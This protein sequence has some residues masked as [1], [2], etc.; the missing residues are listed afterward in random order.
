MEGAVNL[1]LYRAPE[2]VPPPG[3]AV[4]GSLRD[5]QLEVRQTADPEEKRE[6]TKQVQRQASE[7]LSDLLHWWILRMT[8]TRAPLVENMTLFWHGHFATSAEKV[9]QP[10]KT[11]L[12][13][14]TFR[15]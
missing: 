13:N 11:W 9:R 6:L 3:W 14:E 15:A 10:H 7:E 1:L 5:L 12:Q 8:Q 2:S 4:P